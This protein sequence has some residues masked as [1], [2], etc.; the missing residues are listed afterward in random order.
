MWGRVTGTKGMSEDGG[1]EAEE[2]VNDRAY[3]TVGD[4]RRSGRGLG[5]MRRTGTR[6]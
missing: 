6:P 5:E 4:N 1:D 2:R 3:M